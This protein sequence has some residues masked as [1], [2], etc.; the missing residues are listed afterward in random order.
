MTYTSSDV[1]LA[2]AVTLLE[3]ESRRQTV[4]F[5][6]EVGGTWD[7]RTLADELVRLDPTVSPDAADCDDPVERRAIRLYHAALPKLA[8]AD[9]VVFDSKQQTVAPGRRLDA[10]G[11]HLGDSVEYCDIADKFD[12]VSASS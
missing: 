7:V 9:A 12:G 3:T 10:L 2:E 5:L 8:E 11:A 4:A 1:P 6:L